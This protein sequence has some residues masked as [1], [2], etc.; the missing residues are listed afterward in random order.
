LDEPE[1]ANA[2]IANEDTDLVAIGRGMLKNPYWALTAAE[3]LKQAN[4][5]PKKYALGY[6]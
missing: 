4:S 6:Q 5:I 1:V 3:S 2:V